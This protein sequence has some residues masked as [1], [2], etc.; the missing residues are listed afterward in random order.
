MYVYIY[1]CESTYLYRESYILRNE[2]VREGVR[3]REGERDRAPSRSISRPLWF[4]CVSSATGTKDTHEIRFQRIEGMKS[5][6]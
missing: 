6:L 2:A 4:G 3:G 1:I 5:A